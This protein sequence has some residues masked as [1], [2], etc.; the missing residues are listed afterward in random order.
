MMMWFFSIGLSISTLLSI[1]VL[2]AVIAALAHL[3]LGAVLGYPAVSLPQ[4]LAPDD[5]GKNTL[6]WGLCNPSA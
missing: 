1:Q 6:R 4:L 5:L 2:V 3:A